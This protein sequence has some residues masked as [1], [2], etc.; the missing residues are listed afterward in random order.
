M[1]RDPERVDC[2][3]V[4]R[5]NEQGRYILRT[6]RSLG[7]CIPFGGPVGEMVKAQGR[8]G[9]RPHTFIS[10]SARRAIASW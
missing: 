6:V 1:Q 4:F 7:N 5:T 10:S 8:H 3:S 2:R 9:M